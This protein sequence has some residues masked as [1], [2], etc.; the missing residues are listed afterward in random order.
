LPVFALVSELKGVCRRKKT[1]SLLLLLPPPPP[2]PPPPLKR[3]K[4]T[5]TSILPLLQAA[6]SYRAG[7]AVNFPRKTNVTIFMAGLTLC[8]QGENRAGKE[9]ERK[10]EK[11]C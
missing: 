1:P 11:G 5:A 4:R 7:A 3:M 9:T 8:V 10:G 6:P 2:P